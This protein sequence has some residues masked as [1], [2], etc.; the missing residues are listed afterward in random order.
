M[1][2]YARNETTLTPE[3]NRSLRDRR[4]LVAGCGGLGGY[5]AEML[6]RLGVGSLTLADGDS[7]ET[8]NL[9]R[10]LFSDT[11]NLGRP[12][13]E[14]AAERLLA[15]NPEVRVTV[16]KER[17]SRDNAGEICAGHHLIM[18]GLDSISSRRLLQD[19]AEQ[20]GIPLVHGAVA[21]WYGQVCTVFP[22]ERT[23]DRIYPE[24]GER[25]VEESTG[26]PAFSPGMVAS[27][28]VAEGLK[29]LIGRGTVLRNRLLYLDCL[30]HQYSILEI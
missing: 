17:L 8:S 5:I 20:L 7:F 14:A 6:A 3:E 24:D 16:F 9:N 12:K 23:L 21:G 15:V 27:L 19:T 10:Q 13:V 30:N 26:N 28:Q 25:G 22:G 4:V 11:R 1:D 18:D 2:R 29:I